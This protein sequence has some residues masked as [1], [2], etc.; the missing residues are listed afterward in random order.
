[1]VISWHKGLEHLSGK[2]T[3]WAASVLV[4]LYWQCMDKPIK[5][6]LTP[7]NSFRMGDFDYRMGH[8]QPFC[9]TLALL[10]D[11]P[12]YQP[13]LVLDADLGYGRWT[14]LLECVRPAFVER[15]RLNR[16]GMVGRS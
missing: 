5:P 13:D 11:T 4:G 2:F 16:L 6:G 7:M 15:Q 14:L 9:S 8:D 10:L 3:L 12:E 1:M